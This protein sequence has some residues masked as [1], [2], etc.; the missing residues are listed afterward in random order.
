MPTSMMAS[1]TNISSPQTEQRYRYSSGGGPKGSSIPS[2]GGGSG[3]LRRILP[4]PHRFQFVVD[5]AIGRVPYPPQPHFALTMR[6]AYGVAPRALLVPL[7]V[8][9]R[10][11]DLDRLLNEA[12]Y[13]RQGGLNHALQ[14]GK[15]LGR[16]HA[17]IANPLEAFRKDML[18][19][20]SHK[21][22]D[23]YRFPL[24][25]L[26]FMRT[27]VIRDPLAIIAVDPP[28]RDR[29]THHI[30]G[31]IPRQTLIPCRDIP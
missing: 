4:P 24:H 20:A 2:G 11:D 1:L 8:G 3:F 22:V 30:F 15:R 13:F 26:T 10:G 7:A 9:H 31:Q 27:I 21:R 14:L 6:T 5:H 23:C 25:P 28:E 16:L 17:V 29:R 18:H 12:L 19:H